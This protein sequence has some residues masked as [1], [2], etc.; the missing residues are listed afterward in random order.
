MCDV[1]HSRRS[2]S[3]ILAVAI[4]EAIQLPEQRRGFFIRQVKVHDPNM[5]SL[6][7]G[8]EFVRQ[9]TDASGVCPESDAWRADSGDQPGVRRFVLASSNKARPDRRGGCGR[10]R[11]KFVRRG[12]RASSRFGGTTPSGIVSRG[13]N[14][15][16]PRGAQEG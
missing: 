10:V 16:N 13:T 2:L 14:D 7:S 8:G 6:T 4:N 12:H 5:G 15:R 9:H 11:A 3:R 1:V